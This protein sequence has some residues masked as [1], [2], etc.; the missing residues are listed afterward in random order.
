MKREEKNQVIDG[1]TKY[2]NDTTH[3]YITD[4][5]GLNAEDTSLLRRIC[6]KKN[7]K[8]IVA[9]NTFLKKAIEKSNKDLSQLNDA[10]AGPTSIM[11]SDVGNIPAKLI[12]DFRIGDKEKPILKAAF[13]EN[14]FYFGDN[15]IENLV[16]IKSKEELIADVIGLLQSPINNVVS[17]IQ[18]GGY[19]LAGIL[20]TLEER[21]G[22]NN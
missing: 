15:E 19:I 20:E 2:I 3:L 14:E 18:S 7:V 9:K 8:L 12:K 21:D 5:L 1:L 6:F 13:V 4:T 10:L 17:A 22:E 11:L 16:A